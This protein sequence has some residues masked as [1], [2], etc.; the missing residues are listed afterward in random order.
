MSSSL[1]FYLFLFFL[2]LA[3]CLLLFSGYLFWKDKISSA[4]RELKDRDIKK[5]MNR[6]QSKEKAKLVKAS[7]KPEL[8]VVFSSAKLNGQEKGN[9]MGP[10]LGDI[11][12]QNVKET[13]LIGRDDGSLMKESSFAN[14]KEQEVFFHLNG[15]FESD[16]T[17][18]MDDFNFSQGDDTTLVD[19]GT[20]LFNIDEEAAENG[21]T[22]MD[23]VGTTLVDES[24]TT[25]VEEGTTLMDEDG[26]TLVEEGTTL[27]GESETTLLE[28]D[29][30][31]LLSEDGTTYV[32]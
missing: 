22:L 14:V 24:G 20:S 31:T 19:G 13:T 5:V 17:T 21:T 32:G 29:G 18:M 9:E 28:E 7:E 8:D 16:G 2:A 12:F 30:T 10:D 25:L 26:T 27:V 11:S 6:K 15:S 1:F 3:I 23:T 4:Y